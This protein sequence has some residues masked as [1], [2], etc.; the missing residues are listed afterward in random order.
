[1]GTGYD[2][3]HGVYG[4]NYAANTAQPGPGPGVFGLSGGGAGVFGATANG[5]TGTGVYGLSQGGTG[6]MG[7]GA[8]GAVFRGLQAQLQLTPSSAGASHPVDGQAGD[9]FV[10][11][12]SRLW[13]C[14]AGG[15]P[16]TWKQ[17]KLV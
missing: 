17:V 10:D 4:V 3:G 7:D 11:S 15:N 6:V 5:Y 16:A 13:F 12:G 14:T 9:F 8:R 2:L 1:M